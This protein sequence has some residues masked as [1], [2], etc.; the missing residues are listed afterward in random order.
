MDMLEFERNRRKKKENAT[1]NHINVN[2]S[3]NKQDF[4][5]YNPLENKFK[6][7]NLDLNIENPK[8]DDNLIFKQPNVFGGTA[9]NEGA[10]RFEGT[11]KKE[12]TAK[13]EGTFTDEG[14]TR[15][16]GTVEK[17]STAKREGAFSNEGA[18][19]FEGAAE[20]ESTAKHEGTFNN[21]G[22]TK[23]DGTS[24]LKAPN[25]I[26]INLNSIERVRVSLDSLRIEQIIKQVIIESK[27]EEVVIGRRVFENNGVNTS[28]FTSARE[29]TKDRGIIDFEKRKDKNGIEHTW[30]RLK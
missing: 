3:I 18:T 25:K 21:E 28:R 16:E 13:H 19:R 22:A 17:E 7:G 11:V 6:T 9:N 29:E 26:K 24:K 14:A 4:I 27:S 20:K 12:S 23:F 2:S 8:I 5:N 30:Y 15:F 1:V 10:T